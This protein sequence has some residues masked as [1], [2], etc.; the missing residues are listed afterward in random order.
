M[1]RMNRRSVLGG[2]LAVL[3]LGVAGKAA[4]EPKQEE[5]KPRVEIEFDYSGM[6]DGDSR[7]WLRSIQG[8][9]SGARSVRL[10]G[11]VVPR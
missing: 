7:Q 3:P 4:A 2:L 6:T 10:D 9:R 5:A 1:S 8:P 11:V